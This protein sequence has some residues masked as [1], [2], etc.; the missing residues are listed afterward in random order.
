[1]VT[2]M[3]GHE[4][5][6]SEKAFIAATRAG[7]PFSASSFVVTSPSDQ[8]DPVA[9]IRASVLE[10]LADGIFGG[11][12]LGRRGLHLTGARITGSLNL[13][14]AVFQGPLVLRSCQFTD[15]PVLDRV[16]A[17]LL[18][19]RNSQFPFGLSADDLRIDGHFVLDTVMATATISLM[20]ARIG[21]LLSMDRAHLNAGRYDEAFNGRGLK[22][23]A[24]VYMR[25]LSALGS[26]TFDSATVG[27]RFLMVDS[28][29]EAERKAFNGACLNVTGDCFFI[30]IIATGAVF[31]LDVQVGGAFDVRN[32]R[33]FMPGAVALNLEK[34]VLDRAVFRSLSKSCDGRLNLADARIDTLF[35][36]TPSEGWPTGLRVRAPDVRIGSLP[37]YT[38]AS[39]DGWIAWLDAQEPWTPH[40]YQQVG[41]RL[42]EAGHE[43]CAKAVYIAMRR[44]QRTLGCC[45][46]LVHGD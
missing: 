24:S 23:D 5:T 33:F 17:P 21:G 22:V 29:I 45:W 14:D 30:G 1:M 44:G 41:A 42:R 37:A 36:D 3:R 13:S 2:R 8:D 27:E 39:R 4:L 16:R 12:P 43:A 9:D 7:E 31:L 46:I 19:L 18:D 28:V 20:G 15:R 6:L 26:I 40:A 32:S 25:R 38:R 35:L 34:A 11:P 10:G